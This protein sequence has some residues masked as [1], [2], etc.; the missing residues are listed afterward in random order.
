MSPQKIEKLNMEDALQELEIIVEQMEKEELP[1]EK[2]LQHLEKG[3]KLT[4][5]C[6]KLLSEAELKVDMLLQDR[7]EPDARDVLQ[8]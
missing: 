4:Q 2:L 6:R 7:E 3:I 8:E 1:L 5:H